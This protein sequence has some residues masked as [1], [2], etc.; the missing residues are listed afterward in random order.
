MKDKKRK[1]LEIRYP[2]RRGANL[3]KPRT[4]S[5]QLCNKCC[6]YAKF[7]NHPSIPPS[8]IQ[9]IY[10]FQ[11]ERENE[12]HEFLPS[13][14]N[15]QSAANNAL[16]DVELENEIMVSCDDGDDFR[17]RCAADSY[18][19]CSLFEEQASSCGLPAH[20]TQSLRPSSSSTA[21]NPCPLNL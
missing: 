12:S 18:P 3:S 8:K 14:E 15:L 13:P 21:L 19:E 9:R 1:S 16:N 5:H 20:R 6:G 11:L 7:S 17:R 10:N 2:P 4:D